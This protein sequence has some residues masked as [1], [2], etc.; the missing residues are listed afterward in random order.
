LRRIAAAVLLLYF[1]V[2]TLLTVSAIEPTLGNLQAFKTK[3]AAKGPQRVIVVLVEFPDKKHS[4]SV[5]TITQIVFGDLNDFYREVSYGLMSITGDITNRWYQTRT[6]L[7]K[8][9]LE[10][11]AFNSK[12]MKTFEREAIEAAGQDLDYREYDFVI[13]VAAGRVW[14][15]AT[16][17]FNV[18]TKD[19]AG[20]LRGI[21]ANEDSP[22][23]T[24]AH[25]LGHVLPSNFEPRHGCGLP[26]LYSYEAS[27]KGQDP[28]IFVGPW[29]IMAASNP[30][31][32]F[33]AW[34]KME[35][36]WI[37]PETLQL[38]TKI[39]LPITLQPLESN[40]GTRALVLPISDTKYYVVEVRRQIGY[41]S[42]LPSEGVLVYLVDLSKGDGDGV[43]RVVNNRPETLTLD[44]APYKQ[45]AFLADPTSD[46]YLAV[47]YAN[48]VGYF[49]F[50][51]GD[52]S[53]LTSDTSS[54][55][56][57]YALLLLQDKRILYILGH[58]WT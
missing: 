27:E 15:H 45:G 12:D 4:T 5:E 28:N 30:P 42:N 37:T 24:Y 47:A 14:P 52:N 54:V 3:T 44:D 32:H 19:G 16:C 40:S 49:T 29:D 57:L 41:D 22:L 2:C 1:A 18:P 17:N 36:G 8:L 55:K 50:S 56:L 58:L 21:V 39:T 34:S 26:D 11:W 43:V 20:S 7:S 46:L 51:T 35:F 13:L 31:K 38:G 6:P 48:G 33:S 23:G 25:E 9:D 10:E 53:Q